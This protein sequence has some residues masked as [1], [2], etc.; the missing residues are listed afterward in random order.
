MEF[1]GGIKIHVLKNDHVFLSIITFDLGSFG[2][3]QNILFVKI[4]KTEVPCLK[5]TPNHTLRVF[6]SNGKLYGFQTSTYSKW[7]VPKRNYPEKLL[8]RLRLL[9]D[10]RYELYEREYTKS[11]VWCG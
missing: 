8:L 6:E 4:V 11:E 5:I 7:T 9:R 2:V 3:K 10:F 1:W